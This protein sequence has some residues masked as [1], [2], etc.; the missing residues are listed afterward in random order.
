VSRQL[1]QVA[2]FNARPLLDEFL[3]DPEAVRFNAASRKSWVDIDE[4]QR[5]SQQVSHA[6]SAEENLPSRLYTLLKGLPNWTHEAVCNAQE[7]IVLEEVG[8]KAEA[9]TQR[10]VENAVC[11]GLLLQNREYTMICGERTYILT[12][13]LVRLERALIE[14][15]LDRL[16]KHGFRLVSVPDLIMPEDIEACGMASK[17]QR[18]QVYHVD[19]AEGQRKL[20]LSGTAEMALAPLFKGKDILNNALEHFLALEQL[21]I[22]LCAVSRCYRAEVSTFKEEKGLYRVHQFTKV[23]MFGITEGSLERSQAL[24]KEILNIQRALFSDLGLHFRVL[25][26]PPADLG[27]PAYRK[28]DIEAWM[29]GHGFYGEI[30]ST[31]DC[32]SYQANRL[33]I[34]SEGKYVHTINGTACAIPRMLIALGETHVKANGIMKVPPVSLQRVNPVPLNGHRLNIKLASIVSSFIIKKHRT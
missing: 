6:G 32:T 10:M 1:A 28:I 4:L 25:D 17:G 31:S 13:D 29:S 30:S 27:N 26:M 19:I 22:K 21:P 15:T 5:L 16:K 33:G 23:E 2:K 9:S 24:Q 14:Y 18:S 3:R 20:C 7:P 12:G 8:C 11:A 34:T